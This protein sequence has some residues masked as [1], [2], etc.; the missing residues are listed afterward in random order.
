MANE[1][2]ENDLVDLMAARDYLMFPPMNGKID[3]WIN[4]E[5]EMKVRIYTEDLPKVLPSICPN[6]NCSLLL[7]YLKD[8]N[9]TYVSPT[10]CKPIEFTN[11]IEYNVVPTLDQTLKAF[12]QMKRQQAK[13][14]TPYGFSF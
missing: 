11:E 13:R 12:N 7:A 1:I 3:I 14:M 8:G 4:C 10:K 2:E 9:I 5:K 6:I